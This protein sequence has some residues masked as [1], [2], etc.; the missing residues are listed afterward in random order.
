MIFNLTAAKGAASG[1][2][3]LSTVQYAAGMVSIELPSKPKLVVSV[4]RSGNIAATGIMAYC[5]QNPDTG[6]FAARLQTASS[7]S[8]VSWVN[9]ST[10]AAWDDET[11]TFS[12]RI[13]Q[14][15]TAGGSCTVHAVG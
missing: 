3:I 10:D 14:G 9:T 7:G 11:H 5:S 15:S 13:R 1:Y 2:S 6:L 12:M 4:P 8:G